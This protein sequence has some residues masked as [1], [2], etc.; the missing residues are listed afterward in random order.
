M[1]SY[2]LILLLLISA[3]RAQVPYERIRDAEKEPNN[4]LTYSGNYAGH[5]YSPL[6]ELTPANIAE[7]KPLWVYQSREAGKIETS[8]LVVD[9]VLYLTEKPHIVTA[10]DGRTGRPLWMYRRPVVPEVPGCCGSVNRGLAV[11]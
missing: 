3:A 2:F 8:P 10:I 11:L 7:L 9:G 1:K 4:W 6:D 5:R